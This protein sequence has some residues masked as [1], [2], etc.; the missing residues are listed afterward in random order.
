M[1]IKLKTASQDDMRESELLGGEDQKEEE[2]HIEKCGCDKLNH[3]LRSIYW[4]PNHLKNHGV[5]S[6]VQITNATKASE[7][8]VTQK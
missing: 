7:I 8:T 3:I 4:Q 2:N 6:V 1:S 5:K